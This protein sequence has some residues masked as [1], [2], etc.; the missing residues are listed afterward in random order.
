MT[1][2]QIHQSIF[3]LLPLAPS[4]KIQAY[5]FQ[6]SKALKR[7]IVRFLHNTVI[8]ALD[9]HFLSLFGQHESSRV[10]QLILVYSYTLLVRLHVFGLV[11]TFQTLSKIVSSRFPYCCR[12]IYH[13]HLFLKGLI[14]DFLTS[15]KTLP[16]PTSL[17][18]KAVKANPISTLVAR[19]VSLA[20]MHFSK[21]KRVSSDELGLR[22][23]KRVLITIEDLKVC[24]F[25]PVIQLK[26]NLFA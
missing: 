23:K 21:T 10:C 12:G 25:N 3:Q 26:G 11:C 9:H 4:H 15:N 20:Q 24:L 18:T 19:I 6:N 8:E 2:S 16:I 22:L 17:V 14:R 1:S 5:L 13:F 7:F